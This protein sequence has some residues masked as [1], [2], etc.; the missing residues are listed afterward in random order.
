MD[1]DCSGHRRFN[2]IEATTT[3]TTR[4]TRTTTTTE[5]TTKTTKTTTT[6]TTN[7]RTQ[8]QGYIFE[9]SVVYLTTNEICQKEVDEI[10][11][12]AFLNIIFLFWLHDNNFE[13][14]K[15]VCLL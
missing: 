12:F 1:H 4:T 2:S 11:E 10:F 13:K 15:E 5:K 3:R 6:T 7:R 9:N 8:K 14:T